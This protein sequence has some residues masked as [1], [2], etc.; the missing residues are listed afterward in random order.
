MVPLRQ[1]ANIIAD[2]RRQPD[3]P[4]R[5]EPRSRDHRPTWSAARPGEVSADVKQALDSMQ[6]PARLPLPDRRLD[7]EHAGIVRLCAVGAGAGGDLHLH[8]PGS[9]FGS[10]LQ[11]MA[12]MT[13]LPLTLIGVL[14]A[15]LIVPLDAEHVLHHRLHHADGAGDQER[16]PAGRFRQ[17]DA[18]CRHEPAPTR[19]WKRPRCGC[20]RS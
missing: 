11:P 20:A 19:C 17:S 9:Q 6:W 14:L 7:Q 12:I 2:H 15:L 18:A 5:P 8:D 10:F 4:A 1:V 3:Q 13:S 16:D